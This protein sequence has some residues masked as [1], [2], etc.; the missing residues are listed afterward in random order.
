MP[1]RVRTLKTTKSLLQ[2][3]VLITLDAIYI[4]V[5]RRQ[6]IFRI[7]RL[8]NSQVEGTC[9]LPPLRPNRPQHHCPLPVLPSQAN[10]QRVDPQPDMK[11]LALAAIHGSADSPRLAAEGRH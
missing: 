7:C 4:H 10:R 6:V 5:D 8:L 9:R 2:S 11:R 1:S 3:G